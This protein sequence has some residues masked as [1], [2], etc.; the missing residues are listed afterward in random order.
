MNYPQH[1][2]TFHDMER[3]VLCLLN[4]KLFS[5]TRDLCDRS[6]CWRFRLNLACQT[7]EVNNSCVSN[8]GGFEFQPAI[9]NHIKIQQRGLFI[10]FVGVFAS[11]TTEILWGRFSSAKTHVDLPVTYQ[12]A[13]SPMRDMDQIWINNVLD[14]DSNYNAWCSW[15]NIAI[16]YLL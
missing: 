15:S 10:K 8:F 3:M 13:L 7:N 4:H 6:Y 9:L 1:L 12:P 16:F 11:T 2:P 5:S 14:V